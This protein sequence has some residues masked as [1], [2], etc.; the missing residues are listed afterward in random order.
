MLW[1]VCALIA[2]GMA[3]AQEKAPIEPCCSASRTQPT[4]QAQTYAE[5]VLYSF[6]GSTD[7]GYPNAGLA[8]DAQGNLYGTTFFGGEPTCNSGGTPGCGVVFK[9]DTS[10]NETV[11]HTFTNAPDGAFPPAGLVQDAQ[12]NL[13]G[14]TYGG[15]AYATAAYAGGTVF[16]IDAS[17][18]ETVLYSFCPH[19]V[20]QGGCADG[21]Q[22]EAGLVR[23]AQGNLYGT[24]RAGGDLLALG[25]AGGCGTVFKVNS[26]GKETV[27]HSFTENG[28]DGMIPYATLVRDAQG[29]LYGT[30]SE[31]GS[32]SGSEGTVFKVD[33]SGNETVLYSFTENG[34][35][36]SVPAA[37]LV[38]DAQGNLYGTTSEG[39]SG[40]GT[41][42]KLDT[43]G[44]PTLL[45]TF[46]GG[47]D[48][49]YPLAGLA[50]DAKGNLY[51]TTFE[52][53]AYYAGTVFKVDTTGKETVLYSFTGTSGDG[54]GP[55]SVPV[56]DPQGNLY[57]TTIDG[58]VSNAGTVYKL[59]LLTAT[60]TTISSLPNPSAYG[61][62]VTF[63][64][65]VTSTAGAPPDGET[66][67]FYEGHGGTGTG[68]LSGGS[69]TL[70]ATLNVGTDIIRAVYGGDQ[71][72]AGSTSKPESQVVTTATTTTTL[73][74]SQNPSNPGQS[75]TFTATV[76]PQ[77]SG[78][79]T[80]TVTF[81]DG[82]TTLKTVSASGGTAKYRTSTLASGTHSITAT[83]NGSTNFTGSSASLS[84]T[85]N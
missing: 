10:G 26:T 77:F 49:A 31:G 1:L 79:V 48:G 23:D 80:G 34:V 29:N 8:R 25:C 85:V 4:A 72:F 39:G 44:N 46:T 55:L 17:G 15:G 62:A 13:Y 76:T 24:T 42:Y 19:A 59:K 33:T 81:Y 83:Y 70:T 43:S 64:A 7:G 73:A 82:T 69:A 57:G 67:T 6:T 65:V 66:V 63:T 84:Q 30:T 45:H 47:A 32:G 2:T 74:S 68:T 58:G 18:N 3:T 60:T 71:T 21:T 36:G 11:L 50:R 78:T 27:L 53:G 75:V 35:D 56:L 54:F 61:Q 5:S 20:S 28:V 41:V 16:K 40:Y 52:G 22:L 12:G 14:T 38:R 37:G 9:L 51:G